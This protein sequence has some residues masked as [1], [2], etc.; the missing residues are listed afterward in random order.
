MLLLPFSTETVV[1]LLSH[2]DVKEAL[3][4]ITGPRPGLF[5]EPN[6]PTMGAVDQ[7]GFTL[8]LQGLGRGP[9]VVAEGNFKGAPGGKESTVRINYRLSWI[10]FGVWIWLMV[11]ILVMNYMVLPDAIVRRNIVAI[12][13][14]LLFLAFVYFGL[15]MLPFKWQRSRLR[16]EIRKAVSESEVP[17]ARG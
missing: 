6:A 7:N 17:I 5:K 11:P 14:P 3:Q 16:A 10:S 4:R 2:H 1:T 9:V 12:A 8:R 13:L 15:A